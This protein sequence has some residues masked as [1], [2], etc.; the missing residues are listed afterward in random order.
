MSYQYCLS[1]NYIADWY[2]YIIFSLFSVLVDDESSEDTD[3]SEESE[4]EAEDG[5]TV[6]DISQE[7]HHE[8]DET[9]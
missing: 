1:S 9:E 4:D 6:S 3:A 7:L 5:R 8:E 2:T